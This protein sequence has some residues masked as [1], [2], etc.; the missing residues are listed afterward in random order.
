MLP[1]LEAFQDRLGLT[2]RDLRKIILRQPSLLGLSEI[3][4]DEKL[5]F[6][7]DEGK[8]VPCACRGCQIVHLV[9]ISTL[10][11][12][13]SHR[14]ISFDLS[15]QFVENEFVENVVGMAV[16]KIRQALLKQPSMLQYS[17]ETLRSKLEFLRNELCM[18]PMV[19]CRVLHAAPTIFGIS[20]TENL[21]PK[22]ATLMIRCRLSADEV[23][24]IAA[25]VPSILVLSSKR[26]IEP[27]LSYLSVALRLPDENS[28]G[29]MIKA[30]PRILIQSINSSLEPKLQMMAE[31]LREENI[32]E[33]EASSRANNPQVAELFVKNPA[34]FATTNTILARRIEASMKSPNITL[35]EAMRPSPKGRRPKF[36]ILNGKVKASEERGESL[37]VDEDNR[38]RGEG[39]YM[40]EAMAEAVY[41]LMSSGPSISDLISKSPVEDNLSPLVITA[42]VSGQVFPP[43]TPDKPRGL[44]RV[45]G[46]AIQ[47]AQ[48]LSAR[49][50]KAAAESSTSAVIPETDEPGS[51]FETGLILL[52]FPHLRASRHRCELTSCEIA[53]KIILLFLRESA[54]SYDLSIFDVR[55]ELC[56][57]SNYVIKMVKDADLLRRLGEH[58]NLGVSFDYDGPVPKSQANLDILFPLS[59]YYVDLITGRPRPITIAAPAEDALGGGNL[60]NENSDDV[61]IGGS[62]S[63]A[64]KHIADVCSGKVAEQTTFQMY[65]YARE[66]AMWSYDRDRK[67]R[68]GVK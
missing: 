48:K 7:L 19:A 2:C 24:L 10:Q 59:Q 63:I 43:D 46:M 44:D 52:K 4:L 53:L 40:S 8:L 12:F 68:L 37:H 26:K 27:C 14:V 23:G 66:A 30:A 9:L 5:D 6:L 65:K 16:E 57:D 56:T 67:L 25:A 17:T 34:L 42:F 20:L 49:Q 29:T 36:I 1:K 28:L 22:V 51:N 41:S 32:Q 21:R 33:G 38:M 47:I 45:G 55:I 54:S 58:S 13:C 31:A 50:L 64:F 39:G 62:V 60:S 18:S 15:H 3:S 35:A 11:S 61:C